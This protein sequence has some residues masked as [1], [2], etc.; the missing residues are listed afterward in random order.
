MNAPARH[1][2]PNSAPITE[3]FYRARIADIIARIQRENGMNDRELADMVFCSPET[4]TN[5]RNGENKLSGHT[6]FNLLLVSPTALE[7]LLHHFDRRSV[8]LGAKC[9]TDV[10]TSVTGAL[11]HIAMAAQ[12][13]GPNDT[14]CLKMETALDAA[15][16]GLCSLK[17]RCLT[18]R[19]QRA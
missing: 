13:N 6:L 9:D 14:D 19:E 2:L 18:I 4:I 1:V 3:S 15:I 8:P 5:A 7:G 16:D 10:M 12:H 17:S 11:H